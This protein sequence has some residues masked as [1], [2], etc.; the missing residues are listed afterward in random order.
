[1]LTKKVLGV[2]I[3]KRIE[4]GEESNALEI[5]LVVLPC[6]GEIFK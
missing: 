6:I 4:E 1:M 5:D 2:G 3:E